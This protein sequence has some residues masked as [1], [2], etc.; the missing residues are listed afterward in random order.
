MSATGFSSPEDARSDQKDPLRAT[1]LASHTE[2]LEKMPTEGRLRYLFIFYQPYV[3]AKFELRPK[4]NRQQAP[5]IFNTRSKFGLRGAGDGIHRHRPSSSSPMVMQAGTL[6]AATRN[7]AS[8]IHIDDFLL[9]T[10]W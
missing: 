10:V 9:A 3:I 1:V 5:I 2:G 8:K 4:T 7:S 6:R